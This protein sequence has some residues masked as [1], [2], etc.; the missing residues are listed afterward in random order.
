MNN[1]SKTS[2]APRPLMGGVL[3]TMTLSSLTMAM[4]AYGV[5]DLVRYA[6]GGGPVISAPV[7][8]APLKRNVVGVKW[9]M[10][11]QCG[12][13][14]PGL[15]VQNQLNGITDGFQDMMGDMLSNA[16]SAVASLPGYYLQKENPGLYDLMTSG[17]L[18]GKSDFDKSKSSCEDMTQTMGDMLSSNSWTQLSQ[19]EAWTQAVK[20]GDAIQAEITAGNANGDEGVIWRGG[21]SAGGLNQPPIRV[22]TDTV[23]AGFEML[24]KDSDKTKKEGLYRYWDTEEDM[25][26]WVTSIIG[27]QTIQTGTDKS[28]AGGKPGIGLV[29]DV[30]TNTTLLAQQLSDGMN[31]IEVENGLFP[32][33]LLSALQGDPLKDTLA[34]SL[35]SEYAISTSIEKALQARRALLTGKNEAHIAL[36][37]TAQ[38]SI[39]KSVTALEQEIM[40]LRF[41]AET[42]QAIAGNTAKT[43]LER[44]SFRDSQRNS[45]KTLTPEPSR[46]EQGHIQ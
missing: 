21:K 7:R 14:D 35:V 6:L 16:T 18:Q 13:L 33:N 40:L 5:T 22:T 15:T 19:G 29:A 11:L 43:L 46:F 20:S 28:E 45:R 30:E 25:S 4:P 8:Q 27:E 10:N 31:G 1:P 42:R 38:D 34:E 32:D 36:N 9:N 41:E 3:L 44:E 12:L 37:E 23:E 24:T 17:V 26:E 2:T 39:D